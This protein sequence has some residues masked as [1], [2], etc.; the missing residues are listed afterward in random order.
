[1]KT[2]SYFIN[3][4]LSNNNNIKFHEKFR[5]INGQIISNFSSTPHSI[6]IRLKQRAWSFTFFHLLSSPP[7][8]L[9]I[10][11]THSQWKVGSPSNYEK[12][13]QTFRFRLDDEHFSQ[14]T[15]SSRFHYEL[16]EE[17]V[18]IFSPSRER[19]EDESRI[20]TIF[21]LLLF[22]PFYSSTTHN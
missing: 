4:S 1:M 11:Q 3:L 21:L 15:P 18:C 5:Q 14:G 6:I 8:F 9:R 20:E 22:F 7:S 17:V 12:P 10:S 13:N 19:D 16:E 2:F